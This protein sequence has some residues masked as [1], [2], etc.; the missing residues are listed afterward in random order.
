MK[1]ITGPCALCREPADVT[2]WEPVASWLAVEGC[3]CGGF[4][5]WTP[6]WTI[7]LPTLPDLERKRLAQRVQAARGQ[8]AEAWL[9]TADG[10]VD[11]PL[12]V[13]HARPT[14]PP[15]RP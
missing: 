11:G 5:V 15:G 4:L 2:D 8:R 14:S 7:R 13:A 6:L 12:V 9:T 3:Q 10:Q 1:T